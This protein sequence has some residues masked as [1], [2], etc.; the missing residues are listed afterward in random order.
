MFGTVDAKRVLKVETYR[1]IDPLDDDRYADC[2]HC[3][4]VNNVGFNPD[5]GDIFICGQCKIP[6]IV[7]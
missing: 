3:H 4:T 6:F 5:S 1:T 7:E 2:P